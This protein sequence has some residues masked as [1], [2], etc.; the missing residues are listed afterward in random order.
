MGEVMQPQPIS[1]PTPVVSPRRSPA[2]HAD[3][4]GPV[5]PGRYGTMSGLS[6]LYLYGIILIIIMN[7]PGMVDHSM[8]LVKFAAIWAL[9]HSR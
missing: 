7:R 9:P 1:R 6:I 8:S 4:V 3:L 5:S 2:G